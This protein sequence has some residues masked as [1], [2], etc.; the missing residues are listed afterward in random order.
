MRGIVATVV[1]AL[2]FALILAC[3]KAF[4]ETSSDGFSGRWAVSSGFG[5]SPDLQKSDWNGEKRFPIISYIP[6][7]TLFYDI[8]EVT[9][10]RSMGD[11]SEATTHDG[12]PVFVLKNGEDHIISSVAIKDSRLLSRGT[13]AEVILFRDQDRF[14]RRK[15]GCDA[16]LD[17]GWWS[18]GFGSLAVIQPVEGNRNLKKVI[19][20]VGQEMV[21]YATTEDLKAREALGKILYVS[22]T[23]PRL[24][25][26]R[27]TSKVFNTGCGTVK[28]RF[29]PPNRVTRSSDFDL[30]KEQRILDAFA[31]RD[32]D[33]SERVF[34]LSAALG[35][36]MDLD[37]LRG[38]SWELRLYDFERPFPQSGE[39]R[40]FDIAALVTYECR[41]KKLGA[42]QK[43][44]IL[45][46]LLKHDGREI[47]LTPGAT[48]EDLLRHTRFAYLWSVNNADQHFAL[49]EQLVRDTF[50]GDGALTSIF[51]SEFNRSCRSASRQSPD[52][53][54][55]VY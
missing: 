48:P 28:R 14:C 7:F 45:E 26:D 23:Y 22:Q 15:R 17:Q 51:M 1:L 25:F 19:F 36:E 41:E 46:V 38:E 21:T 4:A 31:L 9:P 50:N 49:R 29:T 24:T 47:T 11:Y 39:A 40:T 16:K 44:R 3:A 10:Y 52:C 42:H 43:T 27:Y 2:F 8:D 53:Q 55:H 33:D 35:R 18:V 20:D 6:F 34:E 12:V 32:T 54:G 37:T 30:S 5:I 13:D